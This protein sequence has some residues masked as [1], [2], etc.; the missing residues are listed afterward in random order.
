[1]RLRREE[2]AMLFGD[3]KTLGDAIR[4]LAGDRNERGIRSIGV[5]YRLTITFA[6]GWRLG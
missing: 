4:A 6:P 3:Y 2:K 1:M 5:P